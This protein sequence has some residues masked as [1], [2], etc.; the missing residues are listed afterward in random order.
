MILQIATNA[1]SILDRV[2]HLKEIKLPLEKKERYFELRKKID[3]IYMMEKH[4]RDYREIVE[5]ESEL[6]LLLETFQDELHT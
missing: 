2:L 4:E 3:R 6:N 1:L 5:L